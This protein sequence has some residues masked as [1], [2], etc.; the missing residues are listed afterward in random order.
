MAWQDYIGSYSIEY[1]PPAVI[2]AMSGSH[3]LGV[4]F[5]L[6]T[7][8]GLHIWTGVN[9]IPAGFDSIDP[10]GTVY[11]GGGR[12]LNVPNLE[13]LINGQSSST[14]FGITGIDPDTA[15][16]A[17]D[18]IPDVRGKE[19]K[20]GLT[21]LDQYYQPMSSIIS[22][23]SGTASHPTEAIQPVAGTEQP[24]VSLSLAVV[25]GNNT[26]SRAAL[27]LWSSAHQKAD[28]PTDQF[29][30]NTSRQSRGIAPAWPNNT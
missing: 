15:Q 27:T 11:L 3:L 20:I 6:D 8:P 24:T 7:D 18:S 10:D 22:V 29:C 25:A 28:Y 4:F 17:I 26:R 30:D 13:V 5:R 14:E 2:E 19:V 16:R 9:D 23:W 1:V 12:L 21:T